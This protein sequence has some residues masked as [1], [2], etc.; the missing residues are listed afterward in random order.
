MGVAHAVQFLLD[1]LHRVAHA[2]LGLQVGNIHQLGAAVLEVLDGRF[3]DGL[4]V[5]TGTLGMELD[6]VGVRDL[7]NGRGGDELGMEALGQRAQCRENAL[8]VHHDGL[9]GAGQHHV[10]LAQEV[11]GHGDAVTHG[12]LVAGAADAGHGDALGAVFLGV[13]DHLRVV[14]IEHDHLGQRGIVAVDDNID[15]TLFHHADVGGGIN[16][17]GGAEHHVGELGTH[18]GAAPAIGQAGPQRLADQ[19]LGL[20]RAAHMGHVQ[21]LGDLAV[22]GAGLNARLIPQL[23]GMLGCALEEALGAKGLAVFQQADLGHLMG[24]VIDVLALGLHA[25]L[26]GDAL[27][28]LGVLDLIVAALAGLVQGVH[29]LTAVV[30]VRGGA[31]GGETQIVSAHNAV[32]VAAAD[33][34]GRFGGDAARTHGANTTAGSGFTETAVWGLILCALLPR[35]RAD[36]DAVF[37]QS[38]RGGFHLFHRD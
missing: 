33:A 18:H 13:G 9:A 1:G 17:L 7:G 23:L 32:D 4:G 5:L 36:L 22:N 16:G 27:E 28:L 30:G 26:F 31:T 2:G 10:L 3:D 34:P 21:R 12:D 20:G 29:D 38:G 35:I 6:E 15:V 11:A 19:G 14:G 8:Y 37:Q 24:Q 25:P